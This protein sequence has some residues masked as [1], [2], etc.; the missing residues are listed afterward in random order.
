LTEK[1]KSV[2][3]VQPAL[4]DLQIIDGLLQQ[5]AERQTSAT[6]DVAIYT[7]LLRTAQKDADMAQGGVNEL[8]RAKRLME[9]RNGGGLSDGANT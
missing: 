8:M 7:E 9:Q 6:S 2:P 5:A 4:T 3:P 1:K